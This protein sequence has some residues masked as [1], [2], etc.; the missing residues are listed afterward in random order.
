MSSF[1]S[2]GDIQKKEGGPDNSVSDNQSA[3]VTPNK[4]AMKDRECLCL[5]QE[6]CPSKS[7]LP[8]E[9]E[10]QQTNTFLSLALSTKEKIQI[11]IQ[12]V[13]HDI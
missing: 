12:C 1:K 9:L 2:S 6:Q 7:F 4:L 11:R 10:N 5:F 13:F 3:S 8:T